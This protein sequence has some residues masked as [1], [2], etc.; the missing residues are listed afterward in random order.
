MGKRM[1]LVGATGLVGQGVQLL[2]TYS[3]GLGIPFL[4]T[5]LAV[6]QFFAAFARVR[7]Y[8]KAI[9][10]AAGALMIVIGVLIF[11]NRFTLIAQYLTPYLPTF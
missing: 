3:A 8:Y 1:L 2:A 6:N 4:A 5:S 11:T 7:R 10:I 9:E